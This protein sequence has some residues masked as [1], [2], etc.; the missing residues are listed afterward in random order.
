[1]REQEQTLL[2]EL[3]ISSDEMIKA[4]CRAFLIKRG[5]PIDSHMET[6]IEKLL[7]LIKQILDEVK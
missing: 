1:M 2:G 5:K 4:V 6:A 7:P 3:L